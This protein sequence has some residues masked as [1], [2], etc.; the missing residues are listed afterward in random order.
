M[1]TPLSQ[2]QSLDIIR[3]MI[4]SS[5]KNYS[6]NARYFLIWGWLILAAALIQYLAII[7]RWDFNTLYTWG[8]AIA[9]GG[10]LQT[11][12]IMKDT[13]EKQATTFVDRCLTALWGG[14]AGVFFILMLIGFQ[15]GWIS[16]YPLMITV[17]GWGVLVTG[18]LIRFRPL[19]IG[20]IANFFIA[21]VS[22][23]VVTPEL[24][25]LLILSLLVS[26][27]AP[28]YMLRKTA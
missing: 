8:A 24:I 7:L 15:Y 3:D 17:Y 12:A 10:I 6:Y 1:E 18:A 9:M 11:I 16:I 27:I 20:G 21:G 22:V 14:S 19:I 23:F 25:L 13:R 5:R 2:K 28:A 26:Y 4:S